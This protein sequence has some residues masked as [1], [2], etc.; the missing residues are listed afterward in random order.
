MRERERVSAHEQRVDTLV[1]TSRKK[2]ERRR[3]TFVGQ[4]N[5]YTHA[6]IMHGTVALVRTNESILSTRRKVKRRRNTFVGQNNEHTHAIIMHG[7]L[8]LV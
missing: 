1:V 3:N 4:N 7:T 2:R 8:A 6:I 5:E